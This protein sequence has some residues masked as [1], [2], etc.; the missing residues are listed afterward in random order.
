MAGESTYYLSVNRNKESVA[1]DF[2]QPEGRATL[3]RLIAKADIIVENFGRAR[4]TARAWAT[5]RSRKNIQN[6][7]TCRSQGSAKPARAGTRRGYDAT[8]QAEGGLMS[9]TGEP[10]G[11]PVR[12]GV[13]IADIAS[14]MFAFQGMLLALIARG[15][16]GLGQ[17]VDV[18]LLDSVAALLTYQAS[19]FF[20]TGEPPPRLGNGHASIAPYDALDANDGA[21]ILAVGNDDQWQRLCRVAGFEHLGGDG[22]FETND[23]RVRHYATLRP[24]LT[25]AVRRQPVAHWVTQLRAAG[26]PAGA[27]RSIIKCSPTRSSSRGR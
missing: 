15:T 18:G 19:R 22:R 3:D 2:T 11:A 13:A 26:V 12:L 5:P 4:S 16:T 25:D 10:N 24:M 6:S 8:I 20:G 7:F 14:G 23:G 1:L 9:V 21:L 27:V 17:R